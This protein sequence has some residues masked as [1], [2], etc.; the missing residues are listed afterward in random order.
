M[1]FK[2][3][4][5]YA[6]KMA[7]RKK[8]EYVVGKEDERWDIRELSDPSSDQMSPSIIVNGAGIKYPDD[9]YLYSK[10]IANGE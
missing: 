8:T 10:L 4:V 1:N 7:H 3:T 2:E 6:I 5:I 9:E